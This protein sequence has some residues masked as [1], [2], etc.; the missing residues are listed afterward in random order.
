M[1]LIENLINEGWLKTPR[2]I[3]AFRK[4]RREDFLPVSSKHLYEFDEALYIGSGQTISQPLVVAFMLELLEAGE[5]DNVLDIGSGSGWTSC[6]LAELVGKKGKVTAL[7]I[8][9]ELK[10]FGE[11]NARKYNFKNLEFFLADGTKGF[12]KRAPFDR[13]LVSA[14]AREFSKSWE[15][16]LKEEGIIVFPMNASIWKYTKKSEGFDKEEYP[17]YLFVP[18]VNE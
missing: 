11:R 15:E 10:E 6:L 14:E 3:E 2:I 7:E 17:G 18:L 9:P 1:A 16:Q 5:G 8:I 13:I 4:I 12:E